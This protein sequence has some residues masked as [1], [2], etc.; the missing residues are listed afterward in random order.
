MIRVRPEVGDLVEDET[1][2]HAIVTDIRRAEIWVLRP[3][4]SVT[5]T[6]WETDDP[7][8]LHVL[9]ARAARLRPEQSDR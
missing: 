8:S 7:G 6:Q 2:Q 4:S 9:Q 1:G 3:P 5:R